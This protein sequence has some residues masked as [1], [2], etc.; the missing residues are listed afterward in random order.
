MDSFL[1]F[2][3]KCATNNYNTTASFNNSVINKYM[4]IIAQKEEGISF[5]HPVIELG[6]QSPILV[7][8]ALQIL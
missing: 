3:F 8:F 6:F 2:S 1:R 4:S 5:L 7:G